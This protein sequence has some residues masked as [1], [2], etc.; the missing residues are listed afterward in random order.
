MRFYILFCTWGYILFFY[1]IEKV[2]LMPFVDQSVLVVWLNM[3]CSYDALG[4][5]LL[6]DNN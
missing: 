3:K 5:Y 2:L 1:E 4:E 6:D